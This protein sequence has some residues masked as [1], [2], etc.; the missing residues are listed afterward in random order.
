M[1]GREDVPA[2]EAAPG[3]PDGNP[4][5]KSEKSLLN[6]KKGLHYNVYVNIH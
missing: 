4:Q 6:S 2:A 5:K 1:R 3:R